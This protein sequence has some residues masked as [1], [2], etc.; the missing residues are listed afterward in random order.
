VAGSADDILRVVDILA[1]S[2]ATDSVLTLGVPFPHMAR[3]ALPVKEE[4]KKQVFQSVVEAYT[5]SF[6]QMKA[7]SD[8]YG[9]PVIVA[10]ELPAPR[11]ERSV[12]QDIMRSIARQ[13]MVCY[14]MPDEA[15]KVLN[16]MAMY[17]EFLKRG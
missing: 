9:K 7:I 10:A 16:S 11:A 12:D 3:M 17:G 2:D 6:E 14:G 8:K 13:N 1:K 4:E 15:A 5:K